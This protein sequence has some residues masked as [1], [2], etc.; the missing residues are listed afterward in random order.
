MPLPNG[1]RDKGAQHD[2]KQNMRVNITVVTHQRLA[3]TR[4]CLES[5]LPTLVG[6]AVRVTVVDNGSSDGSREYLAALA[7]NWPQ[8]VVHLLPRN[9]GVAVA[10]NYGWADCDADYYL[11]LDNDIEILK[12]DWLDTLLAIADANPDL[13]QVGYCCCSWHEA[14]TVTLHSGQRFHSGEAC[15]GACVLIPRRVHEELGFWNEDYGLY[16]YEDLD[17]SHRALLRGYRIGYVD[18]DAAVA[19]RGL[20]RDVDERREETKKRSLDSLIAGEKL[21][22]LNAF[23]FEEKIRDL[24]VPR[25]YLPGGSKGGI[26][27]FMDPAYKPILRLQQTLLDKVTY[28]VDGDRISLDLSSFRNAVS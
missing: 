18:D 28:T 25:K 4:L 24:Y 1:P 13:G 7:G 14:E 5:L 21:Y 8:M 26:R 27:F 23:L 17:Y 15:N 6:K 9:M 19:H 12:A 11:K 22:L 10:A 20:E 3:L 2:T 16:G